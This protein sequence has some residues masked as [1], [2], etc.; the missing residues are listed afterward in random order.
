ML[1]DKTTLRVAQPGRSVALSHIP[2]TGKNRNRVQSMKNER[3]ARQVVQET[4]GGQKQPPNDPTTKQVKAPQLG[5]DGAL[6]VCTLEPTAED[7]AR[8]TT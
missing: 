7:A 2:E 6:H 8:M 1:T 3:T 4:Q 5:R